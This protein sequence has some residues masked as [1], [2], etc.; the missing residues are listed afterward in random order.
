MFL[1]Y[2]R[3][4]VRRA[5]QANRGQMA[6]GRRAGRHLSNACREQMIATTELRPLLGKSRRK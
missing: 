2:S 6:G 5:T 1:T 3:L 4:Q